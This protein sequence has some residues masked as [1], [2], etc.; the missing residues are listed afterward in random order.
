M[1]VLLL[2][3]SDLRIGSALDESPLIGGPF[4]RLL[5]GSTDLGPSR[6]EQARLTA[7]LRA[8]ARPDALI[9]WATSRD[10]SVRWR[11]GD[12][13][14]SIEGA[15]GDLA[16]AFGVDV[17]DYR[18]RRGQVY[19]A[20]PQQPSVPTAVGD[21]VG[22][23][24][25]I[26][27]Y[28]PHRIARPTFIPLDVPRHGLTPAQLLTTYNAGPLARARIS[29]QGATI[30]FFEFD[31]YDQA[32][33]DAFAEQSGLPKFTPTLI[34]G[35]PGPQ[36]G[37]TT[38]DLEVAHAIAPDAR[39]VVVNAM[40]TVQ[41]DGA[42]QKIAQLFESVDRQF[43]GAVWSLSIGWGC[44]K[45][46]RTA[47]LAPI[48]A[49]LA[50]AL[51]HGTTAFDAS[52]DMAGLECTG[53]QDWSGPPGPDDVG[54]DGVGSLP[55]MTSVGGTTLSTDSR[56][57][58]LTEHAWFDSPLSQGTS[59]GVSTLFGRPGWQAGLPIRRDTEGR[60][61]LPD[62]AAVADPFTGVRIVFNGQQFVG[63]GTSQAAPIWAGLTVLMNQFLQRHGGRALGDINPMLYRVAAGSD[64]PGFR[65]ISTGG[66]AVDLSVPGYDM[67][68]GLGSPD[69]DNL[70]HDLLDIQLQTGAA[71][72]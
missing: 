71:V 69:I 25:R 39:K 4:A 49:A 5:A 37:E 52:G 33:L 28:A 10:L 65:D 12:N 11:P 17:R 35:Q 42:Y 34:G 56:G 50:T 43:P 72:E 20:S 26:L 15:P 55:E 59:G 36:H 9:N 8:S 23:V 45:L 67:V 41:G 19:Y 7:A 51:S 32:D 21:E 31:G 66:N 22:E 62:V 1:V 54:V 60:R 61:L 47:D 6:A 16:H 58:W 46:L 24:G 70:V 29:G 57:R 30:V 2:L 38:M 48:R 40:P 14:A 64:R 68:T 44:D 53:G 63:A 13:W 18:G 3:A 27:G